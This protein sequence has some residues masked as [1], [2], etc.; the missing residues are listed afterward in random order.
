MKRV[1]F[2]KDKEGKRVSFKPIEKTAKPIKVTIQ[3]YQCEHSWF[4]KLL[5]KLRY[6]RH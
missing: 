1:E 3:M 4:G 6:L 5:L 2:I